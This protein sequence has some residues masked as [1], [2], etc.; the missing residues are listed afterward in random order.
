MVSS[1]SLFAGCSYITDFAVVNE[2][3]R[4][5]EVRYRVKNYPGPFAAP[6]APAVIATSQMSAK[7]GQQWST[8]TADRYQ[9]D[10][11]NRTV[12]VRVMPNEALLV[13][14]MHNYNGHGD[15]WDAKQFPID[16]I[17]IQGSGGEVCFRG[18]QSRT[19]FSE[20]SSALYTITYR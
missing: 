2:S 20:V 15:P 7:G 3:D 11:A 17:T 16:E 14:D 12:T 13:A 5:I 1:V 10:Q 18:S 6:V 19:S 9:L 4:P 8:L